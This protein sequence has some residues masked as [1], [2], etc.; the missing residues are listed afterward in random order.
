MVLFEDFLRETGGFGLYQIRS[1]FFLCITPLLSC[2]GTF[3]QVF[4][5]GTGEH[6]CRVSQWENEDCSTWG[7][8][9]EECSF[10]K[11]NLTTLYFEDDDETNAGCMK[12][13]Y[14]GIDLAT[15]YSNMD[16]SHL[17]IITCDEGW[18]VDRSVYRST[19]TEDVSIYRCMDN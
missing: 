13:N 11:K 8:S 10:L 5:A 18:V 14:S 12:Y 3:T 17:N 1:Y 15:A 16:V 4:T 7:L 6:W 2:I 9:L 19:L